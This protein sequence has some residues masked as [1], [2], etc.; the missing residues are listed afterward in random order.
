MTSD[1][2]ANG[3]GCV[4]ETEEERADLALTKASC[5]SWDQLITRGFP[6][7]ASV[8]GQRVPAILGKKRR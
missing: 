1:N 8:R 6:A 7:R 5:N 2:L 4:R 3:E